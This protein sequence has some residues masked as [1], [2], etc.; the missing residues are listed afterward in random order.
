MAVCSGWSG[1][2][3]RR[4]SLSCRRLGVS[5]RAMPRGCGAACCTFPDQHHKVVQAT[6]EAV[7]NRLHLYGGV[8]RLAQISIREWSVIGRFRRM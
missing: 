1:S 8:V 7:L 3:A 6:L 2:S 4:V 5:M